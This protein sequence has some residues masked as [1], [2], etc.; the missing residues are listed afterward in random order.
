M[1]AT[2]CSC[3]G[4]WVGV[5]ALVL[6]SS[7]CFGPDKPSAVGWP[8]R[9]VAASVQA[10]KRLAIVYFHAELWHAVMGQYP[11][12]L[13]QLV[14]VPTDVPLRPLDTENIIDP[15]SAF[16]LPLR[17]RVTADGISIASI[18]SDR[19]WGG[20]PGDEPTFFNEDDIVCSSANALYLGTRFM[21]TA[22]SEAVAKATLQAPHIPERV[23]SGEK[24]VGERDGV[25]G[26]RSGEGLQA[27]SL[28]DLL[29]QL[30]SQCAVDVGVQ[31]DCFKTH[32]TG[33]SGLVRPGEELRIAFLRDAL[34]LLQEAT[35][36]EMH[37]EEH[38]D[39]SLML[40]CSFGS[41]HTATVFYRLIAQ[42]K[43]AGLLPT[44]EHPAAWP[45]SFLVILPSDWFDDAALKRLET[46]CVRLFG[47]ERFALYRTSQ[48]VAITELLPWG[49]VYLLLTCLHEFV[50][51][52]VDAERATEEIGRM[53]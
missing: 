26:R 9:P 15:F 3:V 40:L 44:A 33:L 21:H 43:H 27:T 36:E 22:Y 29:D 7:G 16:G 31:K 48:G 23:R 37:L 32:Q 42:E 52:V 46:M 38:A 1:K 53:K 35:P 49:D 51:N 6:V 4:M 50:P 45:E 20:W 47:P 8:E 5:L 28:L 18:G 19:R 12:E 41:D 14:D 11:R 25:W 24:P 13:W 39:E 17:Y 34:S 30:R 2:S 10:H